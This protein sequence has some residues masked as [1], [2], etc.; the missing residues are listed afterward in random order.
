MLAFLGGVANYKN[1]DITKIFRL[2][3]TVGRIT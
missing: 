1:N 2:R 3:K